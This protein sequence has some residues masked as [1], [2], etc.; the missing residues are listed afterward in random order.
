MLLALAAW[1]VG[2][3]G[4]FEF[5]TIGDSYTDN[6][7]PYVGIRSLPAILGSLTIPIV[8]LTMQ[9]SGYPNIVAA[10]S[11]AIVLFGQLAPVVERWCQ[12][13]DN[14]FTL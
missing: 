12:C 11:A 9:E 4:E 13:V 7:V 10:F 5:T 8:Y 1:F 6:H 2:F 3:N 14:H